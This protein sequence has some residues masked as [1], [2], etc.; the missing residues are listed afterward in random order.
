ML[1]IRY[2][3]M[4]TN[5]HRS[6]NCECSSELMPG[7]PYTNAAL[8]WLQYGATERREL[9]TKRGGSHPGSADEAA[10]NP[11]QERCPA[12]CSRGHHHPSPPGQHYSKSSLRRCSPLL[13]GV[14]E[15]S[16]SVL[17]CKRKPSSSCF[18]SSPLTPSSSSSGLAAAGEAQPCF[19][20]SVG[21]VSCSESQ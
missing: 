13:R 9:L 6:K 15:R 1:G 3:Y 21:L 2:T 10:E 14:L 11:E 5:I 7:R 17:R 12:A 16:W 18:V 19:P 4:H 8:K 20:L